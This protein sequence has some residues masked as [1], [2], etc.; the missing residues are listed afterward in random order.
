MARMGS[1]FLSPQRVIRFI[2]TISKSLDKIQS[3][4]PS[5]IITTPI[6]SPI[7]LAVTSSIIPYLLFYENDIIPYLLFYENDISHLF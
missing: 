2:I 1:N 5:S 4:M 6:S 3:Y 7:L